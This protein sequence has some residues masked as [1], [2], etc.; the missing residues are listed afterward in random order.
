MTPIPLKTRLAH[1]PSPPPR[2]SVSLKTADGRELALSDPR[3]VRALIAC[4]NVSAVMGG[5]AAHWGGP[6]AFAELTSALFA[7]VF[8][9]AQRRKLPFLSGIAFSMTPATVKT[10]FTPCKPITA[11]P[12]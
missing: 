1:Q 5:A 11:W 8:D 7:L 12:G 2:F 9:D 4:M 6:S 3:A 10:A